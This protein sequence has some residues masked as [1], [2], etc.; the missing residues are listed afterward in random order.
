MS[1]QGI[2]AFSATNWDRPPDSMMS[3]LRVLEHFVH[4]ARRHVLDHMRVLAHQFLDALLVLL[5]RFLDAGADQFETGLLQGRDDRPGLD[6]AG[7]EQNLLA[8]EARLVGRD[9]RPGLRL[10][11][12]NHRLGARPSIRP[13]RPARSAA[14]RFRAANRWS[15][16]CRRMSLRK[17]GCRSALPSCARH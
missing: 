13:A 15:P 7:D 17:T 8:L 5:G 10:F 9:R 1:S 12:R 2:A 3:A 11:A 6:A 16:R 14:A 4:F